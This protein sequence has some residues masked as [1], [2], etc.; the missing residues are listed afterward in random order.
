M[1]VQGVPEFF[2]QF[3]KNIKINWPFYMWVTSMKRKTM[4]L[5]QKSKILKKKKTKQNISISWH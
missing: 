1:I 5:W 3:E 2:T 4:I